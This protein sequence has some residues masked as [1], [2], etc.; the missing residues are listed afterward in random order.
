MSQQNRQIVFSGRDEGVL[1]LIDRFA[2]SSE[3]LSRTL[4]SM[5]SQERQ[6]AKQNIDDYEKQ[7]KLIEERD[8][9]EKNR[10]PVQSNT[11]RGGATNFEPTNNAFDVNRP[12]PSFT[13]SKKDDDCCKTKIEL[14]REIIQTIKETSQEQIDNRTAL[15]ESLDS[16]RNSGG[17][18]GGGDDSTGGR[19]SSSS[20]AG[21]GGGIGWGSLIPRSGPVA[22]GMGVLSAVTTII[23]QLYVNEMRREESLARLSGISGRSV[24]ELNNLE[25]DGYFGR[26]AVGRR[27][28]SRYGFTEEEF[29]SRTAPTAMAFGTSYGI[30]NNILNAMALERGTGMD[31][32]TILQMDRLSRIIGGAGS[33]TDLTQMI[34]GSL[35]GTGAFGGGGDLARLQELAQ[36]FTQ[37]QE[38]QFLRTGNISSGAPFL[39]LR[40]QLELTAEAKFRRD[41]YAAGTIGALNQGLYSAGSPEAQAIK[42]DILRRANPNMGFFELQAEQE[43]GIGARGLLP[44]VMNLVRST[45]GDINQQAILFNQLTGGSMN[46]GD[47]LSLLRGDINVDDLSKRVAG[48]G[49]DIEGR[50]GGATSELRDSMESL[51]GEI[52]KFGQDILEAT[53]M[54]PTGG[55]FTNIIALLEGV[56]KELAR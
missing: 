32:S 37:F 40:R 30:N 33:S 7:I 22:A 53:R 49:L 31:S 8:R 13:T 18:G 45:G 6:S 54:L 3:R 36:T 27:D 48:G 41:D 16:L 23:R 50:A 14:L 26:A 43:K 38:G 25:D 2:D 4:A 51:K 24:W 5:F 12:R 21:G 19:G 34:Y 28:R 52:Q 56:K 20:S 9:L 39:N 1:A 29:M 55:Q 47:I 15:F 42:M 44:G 17:A 46:R 10:R 35:L 11:D